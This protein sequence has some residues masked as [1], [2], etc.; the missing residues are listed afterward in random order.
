[1]K[2][3][4]NAEEGK[5]ALLERRAM[6]DADLPMAIRETTFRT[7]GKDLSPDEVVRRVIRDVRED[8]DNA[9]NYYNGRF[10]GA[11]PEPLRVSDEEMEAAYAPVDD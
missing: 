7:F 8:G 11:T 4:R 6:E 2:I 5:Q 10:D 1:M 3:Y 9:V